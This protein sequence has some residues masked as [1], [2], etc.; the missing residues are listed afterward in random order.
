MERRDWIKTVGLGSLAVVPTVP[1]RLLGDAASS[2]DTIMLELVGDK[3]VKPDRRVELLVQRDAPNGAVVPVSVVSAVPSTQRI[4]ILVNNHDH[5][6]VIQ[7]D[8]SNPM[9]TPRVST[10][11]Q[12]QHPATVTALVESKIGWFSNNADIKTLG[13]RC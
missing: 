4:I 12:L 2:V 9:L 5:A 13:E 1:A 10:H 8:T 7:V 3:A 11:I 6:D